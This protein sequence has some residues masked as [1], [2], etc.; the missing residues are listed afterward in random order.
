MQNYFYQDQQ[1]K[2]IK[3]ELL[4]TEAQRLAK[5]FLYFKNKQGE[6]ELRPKKKRKVSDIR[7]TSSQIRKFFNEVKHLQSLCE[8]RGF[9]W[10]EPLLKMLKAKTAYA[11]NPNSQK[12]PKVFKKFI[13][14]CIDNIHSPDDL[15]AFVKHFE[16]VVGYF[17]GEGVKE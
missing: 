2:I 17:Y 4:S 15:E 5:G 11:A 1:R 13:D 6:Q 8:A 10:V 14:D 12:I 3:A 16:A 7:L 9:E